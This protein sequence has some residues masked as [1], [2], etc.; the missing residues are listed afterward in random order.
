MHSWLATIAQQGLTGV[1]LAQHNLEQQLG[2]WAPTAVAIF[3]VMFSFSSLIGNYYYGEINISHLNREEILS[4]SVP[5]WCN[6]MTFVR[7][8]CLPSDLVWDLADL[9]MAFFSIN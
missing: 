1:A 6:I 9:F 7:L 4:S 2:S 5:Y 8:Y 3:I